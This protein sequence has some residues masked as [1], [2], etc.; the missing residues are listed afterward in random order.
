MKDFRGPEKLSPA[1][2]AHRGAEGGSDSP[3]NKIAL[4]R[5]LLVNTLN[6]PVA[7][8][9]SCLDRCTHLLTGLP[10]SNPDYSQQTSGLNT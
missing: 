3:S 5:L 4:I 7:I 8:T 1:Q 2:G 6:Q 10:V 9:I